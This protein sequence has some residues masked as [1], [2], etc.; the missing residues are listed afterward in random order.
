M[1]SSLQGGDLEGKGMTSANSFFSMCQ[2]GA[3]TPSPQWAGVSL[4][5]AQ[6][7]F[8]QH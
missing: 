1:Q 5:S 4:A 2:T 6:P 8:T 7:H 3:L